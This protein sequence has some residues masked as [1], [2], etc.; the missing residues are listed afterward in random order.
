MKKNID[1]TFLEKIQKI[2]LRGI[3]FS[4]LN[5]KIVPIVSGAT[6]MK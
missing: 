5:N 3:K 1:K 6:L 2:D 4:E